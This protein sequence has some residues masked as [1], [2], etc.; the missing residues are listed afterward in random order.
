[1][2][3]SQFG[4]GVEWA[5]YPIGATEY[6]RGLSFQGNLFTDSYDGGYVEFQLPSI[7]IAG[8]SY[9]YD[10][11]VTARFFEAI[12]KPGALLTANDEF[13]FDGLII[14]IENTEIVQHLWKST[15]W[16]FA[17][18]DSHRIV[19]L[20]AGKFAKYQTQTSRPIYYH[21]DDLR[22]WMYA[23]SPITWMQTALRF[24]DQGL[25]RKVMNDCQIATTVPSTFVRAALL[26]ALTHQDPFLAKQ[27]LNLWPRSY[28]S[29]PADPAAIEKLSRAVS[30]L[31]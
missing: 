31:N 11:A 23:F 21:G 9:F 19:F 27:A 15:Q 6:L 8:D 2:S 4:Y 16:V 12:K 29:D 24:G 5:S 20:A 17:Y 28:V 18:A 13:H 26:F 3:L 7:K 25:A 14:N 10:P 30:S 22:H 1:M